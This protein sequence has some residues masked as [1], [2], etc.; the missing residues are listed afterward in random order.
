MPDY[1]RGAAGPSI[2]TTEPRAA[3]RPYNDNSPSRSAKNSSRSANG[4]RKWFPARMFHRKAPNYQ[5][6]GLSVIISPAANYRYIARHLLRR[7][8]AHAA[9]QPSA[10]QPYIKHMYT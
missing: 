10:Q 8:A 4:R 5:T 9:N 2:I 1:A 3:V 7:G 6:P